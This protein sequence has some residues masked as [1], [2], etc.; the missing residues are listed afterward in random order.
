MI[1]GTYNPRAYY[2]REN[3]PVGVALFIKMKNNAS[4][5]VMTEAMNYTDAT[6]AYFIITKLRVGTETYNNIT[7]QA[8]QN[9][10]QTYKAFY[11]QGEEKLRIFYH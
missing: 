7:Q 11:Y 2:F 8:Q 9:G 1:V 5:E 4:R 10:L 3:D 6:V